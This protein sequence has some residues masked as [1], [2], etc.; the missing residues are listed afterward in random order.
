MA[1][2]VKV[3]PTKEAKEAEATKEK[4]EMK[5]RIASKLSTLTAAFK[6]VGKA[7]K[8]KVDETKKIEDAKKKKEEDDIALAATMAKV[9]AKAKVAVEKSQAAGTVDVNPAKTKDDVHTKN[10]GATQAQAA[11]TVATP[12]TE[13]S[14]AIPAGTVATHPP[15]HS[16]HTYWKL[17]RFKW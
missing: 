8:A 6:V 14:A 13:S 10:D 16:P 17:E 5:T 3:E 1:V 4:V 9:A 11:G 15:L 2:A 12:A 7:A